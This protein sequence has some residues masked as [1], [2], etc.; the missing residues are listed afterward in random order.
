MSFKSFIQI[1][2]S[3]GFLAAFT[4]VLSLAALSGG[5]HAALLTGS[6]TPNQF[7]DGSTY[8]DTI[9][10]TGGTTV[11]GVTLTVDFT[12][13]ATPLSSSDCYTTGNPF[14]NEI[15]MKLE[16]DSTII[17][18]VVLYTF[19]VTNPG[20]GQ[21]AVV[22]FD[23]AATDLIGTTNSSVPEDGTFQPVGS[24]ASFI[25][26][27]AA[28]DWKL[29]A[30]DDYLADPLW[31]TSWEI[32]VE[33]DEAVINPP[34][35]PLHPAAVSEPGTLAILGLGLAGLSLVRRRKNA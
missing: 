11:T 10:L 21:R 27:T 20:Q 26:G 34:P 7:I 22:T 31:L 25:G 16:H 18:L 8:V 23:D 4:G 1:P 5:T 30:I 3:K 33:T 13:C 32:N 6:S 24:L 2:L 19:D 35:P 12:K 9:S 29:I 28:G 15:M 17:D 14:N